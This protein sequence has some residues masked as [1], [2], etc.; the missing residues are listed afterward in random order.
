MEEFCKNT[1]LNRIAFMPRQLSLYLFIMG[2]HTG[3]EEPVKSVFEDYDD[4]LSSIKTQTKTL[5]CGV[6]VWTREL[7]QL[8]KTIAKDKTLPKSDYEPPDADDKIENK[9][10][11]IVW[12]DNFFSCFCKEPRYNVPFSLLLALYI[13]LYA[14]VSE[15][16]IV[17]MFRSICRLHRYTFVSDTLNSL[18]AWSETH[19]HVPI[20]FC[21]HLCAFILRDYLYESKECV[22]RKKLS[23]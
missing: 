13:I 5:E 23:C 4:V 12:K 16:I 17:K 2:S 18:N 21:Q 14:G 6:D 1:D 11:R 10:L 7:R 19:K 8:C 9:M 20:E 22:Q 15:E 3:M